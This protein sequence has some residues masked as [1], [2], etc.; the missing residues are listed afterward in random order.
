[1][2]NISVYNEDSYE[3]AIIEL[4]QNLGYNYYFGPDVE[5]DYKDPIFINDLDKLYSINSSLDREAIDKAIE[6]IKDFG[7][8]SLEDLNNKFMDYLQNGINVNYWKG[9]KEKSTHVKLIGFD[10]LDSNSFT[11]INQWTVVD[12]EIKI[13]DVVVFVNGFPLV[14]CE[15]KSPARDDADTSQAYT[16]SH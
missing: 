15:L 4:F 8:G 9:G 11:V 12:K 6:D 3:Q 5:R 16:Q 7:I 14:V 10:N 1:M 2:V 13:P